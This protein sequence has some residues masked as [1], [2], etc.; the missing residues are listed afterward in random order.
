MIYDCCD[1]MRRD[2]V[3]ASNNKG[4][5]Q[6]NGIDYLEVL[7]HGAPSNSPPQ[8]TL[9]VHLLLSVPALG[10]DNVRIEG[11]A[12]IRDIHVSWV[13]PADDPP[14]TVV[15]PERSYFTSLPN[16]V[17]TLLVRT[18]SNGDH[19]TYTLALVNSVQ[20]ADDSPPAG[21]DPR[22]C[23]VQFSFKVECPSPFDCAP[24]NV[25]PPPARALPQINYLAKDYASFRTLIL[26]RLAQLLPTWNATSAAD[27]GITLT[28]L[29]AYVGDYLSYQQDAAATEAYLNTARKRVSL[30]RHAL[31]VDYRISD[32]SN[33][34]TWVQVLVNGDAVPL[35]QQG[36]RF[37]T[38]VP[39]LPPVLGAGTRELQLADESE[40]KVFEPMVDAT[41]Y[42]AHN[43]MSFYTWG[44]GR[45]C[46]PGGAVA[47]TLAGHFPDLRVADV[48]V[49]QEVKGPATGEAAD[50]DPK[51]RC[52]VR[53]SSVVAFDA[54]NNPLTDPLPNPDGSLNQITEIEWQSAD[55]L[56]FP[57]C[58]SSVGDRDHGSKPLTDVSIALGN[59]VPADHGRTIHGESLGEVPEPGIY[60]APDPS[61]PRCEPQDP[62]AVPVRYRP[63]LQRTPLTQAGPLEIV[64][65][66]ITG[67][68]S[69]DPVISAGAVMHWSMDAVRP[70]IALH[71]S[72]GPRQFDWS[73]QPDLL[74]SSAV[75]NDFVAET[76]FDGTTR[77]RFGDDVNG[78]RPTS[79]ARFSA[80]YRVGNGTAGNIGAQALFHVL[81]LDGRITGIANPL[82]A[83]GGSDMEN[84]EQIRRRAPQAYRTQQRCVTAADYQHRAERYPSVQR[85]AATFR[86]TGSWHTVFVTVDPRGGGAPSRDLKSGLRRYLE[87]YRMAGYDLE[88]E[89]PMYVSLE[90]G[91]LVCVSPDY[92]R[93]DVEAALL[94]ALG[95]RELADG[96]RG[97]FYPDNFSFGQ[98]VYL[99]PVYA[100]ARGV[101]GVDSIQ[102]TKFQRQGVNDGQY[103]V[104]GEMP[105]GRLEIARLDNDP[106]FPENGI[107]EL[108]MCG[109]K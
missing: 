5:V 38:R 97:L 45:C 40:A 65:E 3:V 55:A 81:A 34:R 48:L 78:R 20:N 43:A 52:A 62:L 74:E 51:Q 36:T 76:E 101:E 1:R 49:F 59:I 70:A 7:D 89:A 24:R 83:V 16:A 71:E 21:F 14:P 99:S 68:K 44:D 79:G 82:P 75:A 88:L 60:I 19:S 67:R 91:L 63:L 18:D 104:S 69:I 37:Y 108:Q 96:T 57:I 27:M 26:D 80:D 25:C 98:A 107:L 4:G 95:S 41:L 33:A 85:A 9:L 106:D 17:R 29:V 94:R 72:L 109:G 93:S 77:L 10:T 6:I 32:G 30:R 39:G 92:F 100:R 103:L 58:V 35:T 15:D 31:L 23:E 50:A 11:G 90:I 102:I 73:P 64:V 61:A 46:L 66:P 13:A 2:L 105:L 87:A 56:P 47:A 54:A 22:L 53:L 12:R 86:W 84:A 28:E 8:R 42:Q